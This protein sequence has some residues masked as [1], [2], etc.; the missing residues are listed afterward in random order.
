MLKIKKFEFN[1][2]SENTYL[3]Y[4]EE[5]NSV[6]IS[7]GKCVIPGTNVGISVTISVNNS[8]DNSVGNWVLA[9]NVVGD[10]GIWHVEHCGRIISFAKKIAKIIIENDKFITN[11]KSIL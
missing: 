1:P 5:N 4:D 9:G 8:V 11:Q 10:M 6:I 3:V 7:V 2:F